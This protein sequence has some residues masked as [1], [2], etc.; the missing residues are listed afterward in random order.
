MRS[1]NRAAPLLLLSSLY[2]AQG[3][4]YGFFTQ[5]LPVLMRENGASLKAIS[6]TSLLFLPW[7]LKFLWAPMVDHIG[8]RRGW[9]LPIQFITAAGAAALALIDRA[10]GMGA[11]FVR[12]DTALSR[13]IDLSRAEALYRLGR[14]QEVGVIVATERGNADP[15]VAGIA[16]AIDGQLLLDAG[17]QDAARAAL[18]QAAA[19]IGKPH[20]Y[21]WHGERVLAALRARL[22]A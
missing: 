22:A 8:T 5:A 7:A 2:I 18:D 14:R 13:I 21:R 16:M 10:A 12:R 3:L 17:R 19:A 20:P 1:S 15:L 11:R 9:I 6:A 4:P